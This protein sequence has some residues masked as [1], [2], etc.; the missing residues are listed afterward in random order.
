M[1]APVWVLSVDLQAKTATFTS[2][3]ADAAKQ[4]RGSFREMDSAS[5]DMAEGFGR[6]GTNVRA[7]IGLIDNTI[8]GAHAAAM[9]DLVREFQD[10]AVVM[11]ALPFAAVIGGIA[12]VATI[13]VEV[14]QKV[15][16]W[17]EEQQKL[18]E[19]Q[20]RFGTTIQEVYNGLDEKIIAA[21]KRTD[22]LRNDH[23][24]ALHKELELINRQ[25]FSELMHSF[26][27]IA[28]AADVVF[29]DLKSHWYTWGIGAAGA[30][31]AL[32][33]FKTQYDSLLSQGK[34]K[35]ASDLLGGTLSSAREILAAQKQAKANNF[36]SSKDPDATRK[37][38]QYQEAYNK[39]RAA[40]VQST[41]KE[42]TAQET[43]IKALEAQ[44]TVEQKVR[45]LKGLES[46]NAKTGTGHEI[47]QLSS[48]AAKEAADSAQRLGELSLSADKAT[49]DARLQIQHASIQERLNADVAFSNRE[50]ALQLTGN[51]A[52][53]SAL[54]KYSKD[55]QNQLKAL[56]DKA[57]ELQAQHDTKIA[58]MTAQ[59]S[60]QQAALD[61]RNMQEAER[62][63]IAATDQGSE[64]RLAAIDAAIAEEANHNLQAEDSYRALLTQRVET[65]RQKANEEAQQ[66]AEAGRIAADN[67]TKMAM[68]AYAAQQQQWSL[69]DSWHRMTDQQ[70]ISEEIASA[71]E[72]Y[73]IQMNAF[74][75]QIA[76]LDKSG[77]D[78]DNKLQELQN[79]QKQLTRQHEN[80]VTAIQDQAAKARNQAVLSGYAEFEKS[81]AQGT[82]SVLLGQQSFA[83]M[84]NSLGSQVAS[85]MI[86]NALMAIMANDMTKPSRAAAAAR[87]AFSTTME[88]LP[89]P[90][91]IVGAPVAGAAAFASVMAY[92]D[93]GIV[94]GTGRGDVVPAMLT[95]GEGVVPGGVMDGL[96]KMARDGSMGGSSSTHIHVKYSPQVTAVDSRGVEKMLKSHGKQ[97]SNEFHRQVRRMNK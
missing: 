89:F 77:K 72:L 29:G 40:G 35:A 60:V 81:I 31:H 87:A 11:A 7:A 23:I 48:A 70:R 76:A 80:E 49:A 14:G 42:I 59:A 97:F 33:G 37:E 22:E 43:L 78:Y 55:Y 8:R 19:E 17:R 36:Y 50:L 56:H 10:S 75:Q 4:A 34:D 65:V 90:A 73:A 68:L 51:Q 9:A 2:G 41:E 94:P 79:R 3:L 61:V 27:T 67:D 58:Q 46:G 24:G 83:A 96:S 28:K 25:S 20:T 91:N 64:E 82:A 66:K 86:R 54:D 88:G 12:A 62:Q 21:E 44:G 84:M 74:A 16:E 6:S 5:K 57:A 47:A 30:S 95:P 1:A 92:A 53:I 38:A 63:K 52:Q 15:K 32:E 71:N 39:L 69:A 18:R 45:T 13:A 26:E 93:G 85:G